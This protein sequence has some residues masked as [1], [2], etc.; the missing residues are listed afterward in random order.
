MTASFDPEIILLMAPSP[1]SRGASPI[2]VKSHWRRC[3]LQN[4]A[5]PWI[6]AGLAVA[7]RS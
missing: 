5:T 4:P 1:A 2:P 3:D 7:G 6:L